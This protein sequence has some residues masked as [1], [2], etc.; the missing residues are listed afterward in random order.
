MF[1]DG[2]Y[3]LGRIIGVITDPIAIG[4]TFVLV[5]I[6]YLLIKRNFYL[7]L[8]P[9]YLAILCKIYIAKYISDEY[10]FVHITAYAYLVISV[11]VYFI[12]HRFFNRGKNANN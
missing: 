3:L 11:I 12:L 1:I 6:F 5:F 7:I 9:T 2:A 10:F 8:V 4:V